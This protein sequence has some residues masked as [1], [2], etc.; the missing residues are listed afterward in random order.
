[1]TL[2]RHVPTIFCWCKDVDCRFYPGF[3]AKGN[4]L[5]RPTDYECPSKPTDTRIGRRPAQL[6]VSNPEI[7]S[8]EDQAP[9]VERIITE[10]DHSRYGE[11]T[12]FTPEQL[13]ILD[14]LKAEREKTV[15][16]IA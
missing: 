12:F 2:T 7:G 11:K 14:A 1:M 9:H 8:M 16:A 10:E 6:Y 15:A 4:K 13:A 3:D 5:Q